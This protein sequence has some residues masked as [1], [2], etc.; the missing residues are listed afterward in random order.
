MTTLWVVGP[1]DRTAA[2]SDAVGTIRELADVERPAPDQRIVDH[3]V[4]LLHE[5]TSAHHP[6]P[7]FRRAAVS[8]SWPDPRR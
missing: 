1:V 8:A 4:A 3:H 5:A 6:D 2:I 7:A